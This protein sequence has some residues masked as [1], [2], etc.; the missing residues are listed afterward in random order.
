[1]IVTWGNVVDY[2]GTLYGADIRSTLYNKKHVVITAPAHTPEVLAEHAIKE[3][4]HK[5]S[6]Q[7]LLNGQLILEGMLKDIVKAGKNPDAPVKLAK[8]Q[9]EIQLTRHGLANPS[10]EMILDQQ[11]NQEFAY[12]TKAY[13]TR[14]KELKENNGKVFSLI[15]GQCTQ[16]LKKDQMKHDPGWTKLNTDQDPLELYK[17]IEKTVISQ[18]GDCYP[19]ATVYDHMHDLYTKQIQPSNQTN[20]QWYSTFN[21]NIE[22]GAAIGV[23]HQHKV[24]LDFEAKRLHNKEFDLLNQTTEQPEIRKIAEERYLAYVFLKQSGKQNDAMGIQCWLRMVAR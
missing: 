18:S 16:L 13:N 5:K 19:Y 23:T 22:V 24:L 15:L 11:D 10:L 7:I 12:R 9:N 14:T 17:L 8:L 21:T 20:D 3:A 6:L 2:A 1:V 4:A